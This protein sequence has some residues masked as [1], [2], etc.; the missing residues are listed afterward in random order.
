MQNKHNTAQYSV[1]SK[2]YLIRNIVLFLQNTKWWFWTRVY[3]F[4]MGQQVTANWC[5]LQYTG[6]HL[7]ALTKQACCDSLELHCLTKKLSQHSGLGSEFFYLFL[8]TDRHK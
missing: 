6:N 3:K 1:C 2:Q 8:Y 4:I 7:Y 5:I